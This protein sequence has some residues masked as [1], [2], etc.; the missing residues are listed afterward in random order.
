MV[1]LV[2]VPFEK[3]GWKMKKISNVVVALFAIIT[4]GA[5]TTE[6]V[7][8]VKKCAKVVDV[9]LFK[10]YFLGS[11]DRGLRVYK[12]LDNGKRVK[13]SPS[14]YLDLDDAGGWLESAKKME[15]G[16]NYCWNEYEKIK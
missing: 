2:F 8:E 7:K 1:T 11:P 12:I 15:I 13:T 9:K 16:K 10:N 14:F 3:R 5:C 6:E 4:L